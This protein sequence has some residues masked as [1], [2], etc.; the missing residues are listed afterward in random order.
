MVSNVTNF[1]G[2]G[3]AGSPPSLPPPTGGGG[4]LERRVELLEQDMRATREKLDGLGA[5]LAN[6]RGKLED[7]PTKDWMNTRLI[8]YL[9][10]VVAIV[11]VMIRYLPSA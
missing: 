3:G 4:S 10:L 6:I 11:G 2:G 5:D 9:M 7:M 8:A 1:P